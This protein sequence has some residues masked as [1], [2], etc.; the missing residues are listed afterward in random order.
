MTM[1]QKSWVSPRHPVVLQTVEGAYTCLSL[2]LSCWL[3]LFWYLVWVDGVWVDGVWVDVVW[4]SLVVWPSLKVAMARDHR[5][6]WE[7]STTPLRPRRSCC[8]CSPDLCWCSR[9]WSSWVVVVFV[10]KPVLMD[11]VTKNLPQHA[12]MMPRSNWQWTG[13]WHRCNVSSRVAVICPNVST[14]FPGTLRRGSMFWI[15]EQSEQKKRKKKSESF[16]L[17]KSWR[18]CTNPWFL[19]RKYLQNDMQQE[20]RCRNRRI[21]SNL[22]FAELV[23][24]KEFQLDAFG[25]KSFHDNTYVVE[26]IRKGIL[27]TMSAKNDDLH[28]SKGWQTNWNQIIEM[29]RDFFSK[30]HRCS[31][32]GV[33]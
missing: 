3:C 17:L 8:H 1:K 21:I 25:Q 23:R 2:L 29:E 20:H 18:R 15:S 13:Y 19:W 24:R 11:V 7:C 12:I 27:R 10:N 14:S 16:C 33:G 28:E 26:G 5:S 32:G 31:L 22:C 4:F 30:T 9:W 6:N